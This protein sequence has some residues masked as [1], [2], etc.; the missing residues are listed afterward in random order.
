MCPQ[1]NEP[2]KVDRS[3]VLMSRTPQ[4]NAKCPKCGWRG[5]VIADV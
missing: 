1:C 3:E 5:T 4:Y 2:I